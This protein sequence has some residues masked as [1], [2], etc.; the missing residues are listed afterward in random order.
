MRHLQFDSSLFYFGL[1]RNQSVFSYVLIQV[2]IPKQTEKLS[3][4]FR[5]TNRK[6]TETDRVSVCF[7]SNRKYFC[8]FRGHATPHAICMTTQVMEIKRAP[9][10]YMHNTVH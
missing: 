3:N 9:S 8:L 7:G 1:L 2:H 5:E 10:G 6:G 4:W